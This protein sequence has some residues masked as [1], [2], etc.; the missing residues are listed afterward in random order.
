VVQHGEKTGVVK[1][2]GAVYLAHPVPQEVNQVWAEWKVSAGDGVL[3]LLAEG[4]QE[5]VAGLQQAARDAGMELAGG[6]FPEL[7]VQGAFVK[8]GAVLVRLPKPFRFLLTDGMAGPLAEWEP[9][10]EEVAGGLETLVRGLPNPTLF[11]MVDAQ[12]V[13]TASLLDRIYLR[14]GR[15]ARYVGVSVGSESFTPMNCLFD[16]ERLLGSGLLALALP[17]LPSARLSHGYRPPKVVIHATST[18][19]N[20]VNTINWEP[21]FAVYARLAKEQ[22][23]VDIHKENFYQMSVH[24]PFGLMLMDGTVLVRIPVQLT[25]EGH[26]YCVGEIPENALLTLLQAPEQ[27]LMESVETLA[28]GMN[29]DGWK[30]ALTFYCAGRRMHLG[31]SQATAELNALGGGGREMVGALTLGEIGHERE[32]GYPHFHNGAVVCAPW[33]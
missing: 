3:V 1:M 20:R 22:Y 21:A 6:V 4:S 28:G 32:G 16:R 7:V 31:A 14:V 26:L 17:G 8:T 2:G 33:I 9:K 15:Q 12:V 25:D 10:A 5:A 11:F 30:R 27:N 18:C 13:S 23:G 29:Q 19:Q 24:F